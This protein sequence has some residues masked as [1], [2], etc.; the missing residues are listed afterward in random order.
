MLRRELQTCVEREAVATQAAARAVEDV[1]DAIAAAQAAEERVEQAKEEQKAL[2]AEAKEEREARI[3]VESSLREVEDMLNR[4][5]V[6]KRF[7]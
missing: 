3:L 4:R 7:R 6:A 1:A 5:H 2:A